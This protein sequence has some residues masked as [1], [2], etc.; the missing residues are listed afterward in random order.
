MCLYLLISNEMLAKRL[1][2]TFTVS[3]DDILSILTDRD[4]TNTNLIF[5]ENADFLFLGAKIP[6]SEISSLI[7]SK[8][9]FLIRMENCAIDGFIL[10]HLFGFCLSSEIE[11]FKITILATGIN[12]FIMT[13]EAN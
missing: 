4:G 10:F 1:H 5:A 3:E 6:N 8:D 13:S 11:Y 9:F 7:S 12:K 2:P